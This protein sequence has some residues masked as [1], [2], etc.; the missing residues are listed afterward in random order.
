MMTV[1]VMMMIKNRVCLVLTVVV[2]LCFLPFGDQC[3]VAIVHHGDHDVGDDDDNDVVDHDTEE[4][5]DTEWHVSAHVPLVINI[6]WSVVTVHDDDDG[7]GD[8]DGEDQN[9]E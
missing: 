8:H 9:K 3:S 7:V 1:I 5:E 4:D 6:Q 2:C